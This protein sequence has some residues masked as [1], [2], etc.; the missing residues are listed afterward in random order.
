MTIQELINQ[1]EGRRLEFK[2]TLPEKSDLAKTIVSFA[3]DAGGDL[4]IGIDDTAR[5]LIGLQ[6]D[7]LI[8]IEEKISNII[9]DRCYPAILPEIKFLTISEKHLIQVTVFRG[10]TP[11]Y[12][13]KSKGKSKGTFIRVGSSNRLADENIISELERRKRNISFDS[14][15]ILDKVAKELNIKDFSTFFEEKTEDKLTISTLRKLGLLKEIN[16]VEY[17]TNALIL[18]SDDVLRKS[19]FHFAKV[20]CARFRGKTSD[21]FIDQKSITT[22]VATQAEEAYNFVLRHINKGAKVEG[23]YTISRWEYPIKAIREV[24]RNA[25][26]HR[27]YSLVGKDIK[28]AIYDHLIE[29]TSPGLLPPSIDYSQMESRQSDARNRTL[30]PVFKFM[31]IIDQWGNGLK[32]IFDELKEYPNIELRWKEVGISLQIQFVNLAY[33]EMENSGVEL[34]QELQQDLQQELQ[35][36]LLKTTLFTEILLQI[37][38]SIFS[39]KEISIALNQKQI[40]GQLNQILLQLLEKELIERTIPDNPNHPQQK[41]RITEKGRLFVEKL[42]EGRGITN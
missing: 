38:N 10:S 18:F 36:E 30:A 24:I 6:E 22:N 7:E 4:L 15:L 11:P 26:V 14:E 31:G 12:Y 21:E 34:G 8:Q 13:I 35:Q 9:F 27:D 16:G 5:E 23:V 2:G 19:L 3:N 42:R 29:I 33:N 20:E 39:R 1:P 25:V 32:L 37:G 28:V 40:S 17:P 41:F